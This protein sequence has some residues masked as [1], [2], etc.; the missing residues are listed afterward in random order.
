MYKSARLLGCDY[1]L[2]AAEMNRVLE[3]LG[4]LTGAPQNYSIT[5]KA[6]EFAKIKFVDNSYGAQYIAYDESIKNVLD[7]TPELIRQVREEAAQARAA[8]IAARKAAQK[9]ADEKYLAEQAAKKAAEL[10]QMQADANYEAFIKGVKFTGKLV[11]AVVVV[12]GV[13]NGVK[14]ATPHVKKWWSDRKAKK[15]KVE[16]MEK[17]FEEIESE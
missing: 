16:T 15:T 8:Q 1:G 7:I 14:K 5:E 4:F 9:L 11:V 10:A 17:E 3:K 13:A 2:T 6:K 12:W